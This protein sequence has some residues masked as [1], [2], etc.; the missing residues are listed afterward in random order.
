MHPN[1]IKRTTFYTHQEHFEFTVVSFGLTNA[2]VVLQS[3]LNEI[4]R[5]Y[6][7][8]FVLVFFDDI[9]IYNSSWAKRMQHVKLLFEQMCT[10]HLYIKKSKCVFCGTLM[11]YF[12]H[13]ISADGVTMDPNKI[14]AMDAWP[15]PHTM[16]AL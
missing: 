9:L 7:Q 12:G 1:D 4:L 11:T 2:R 15:K 16:C 13:V 5:P 10:H 8:K 6:I 3:L 14:S